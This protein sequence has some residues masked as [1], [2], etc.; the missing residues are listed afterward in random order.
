M[1]QLLEELTNPSDAAIKYA[2]TLRSTYQPQQCCHKDPVYT[3]QLLEALT[4]PN[5]AA[6]KT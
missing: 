3:L 2:T 4:N 6:T 5:D 1:L